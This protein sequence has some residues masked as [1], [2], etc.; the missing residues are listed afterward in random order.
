[1]SREVIVAKYWIE[2]AYPLEDAARA[3]AGEQSCG[4]FVRVPGETDELRERFLAKVVRVTPLETVPTP[5]LPGAGKPKSGGQTLMYQRAELEIAFPLDNVG[6]NLPTLLATVAGNLFELREFSGLRLLDLVLPPAF[7]TCPG[8]QF[9]VEGTR[10]LA[11]VFDRPLIGTIVK[12]SV[13]L[14]PQQTAAL[15]RELVEAGIDFIKD[16]ELMANPPHSPLSERVP[17][18]MH[19]IR[20]L[21][22]RTG[23]QVM[24]AFNISDEPDAMRRHHDLVLAHHG[25]CVMV[26]LHHVG[27][28]GV[29][30]LR[31]HAQVPIHGHRN[32]WGIYSRSPALGIEYAAMQ[33]IWR[34]AGVDHLHVNGLQNKFCESDDSVERSIKACLTPIFG[35]DRALP[36][37]S[38][39]QWGGQ[40][41]ETYRRTQ[42]V[43]LMYLAGGGMMAHPGGPAAGCRALQQ[44]WEA[45][46][47]G[48]A[49]GEY[50][51][52]HRELGQTLEKFAARSNP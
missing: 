37:V 22:E 10:R 39:G 41:P 27:L 51:R 45:A 23:K 4:T 13:G 32:G 11:S 8:P 42:T 40:A 14:S 1:M 3:L 47:A 50:A 31:K 12:P 49:L 34:L 17:A 48:I 25:T 26:S 24:Y 36:V 20:T 19:E 28:A 52:T 35:D 2:T 30:D 29:L 38:S 9:G 6:M 15:V 5:S 18:V 16:D 33:K 7:S 44:A 21:A 46:V 43:D